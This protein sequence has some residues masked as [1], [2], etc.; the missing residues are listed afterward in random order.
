MVRSDPDVLAATRRDPG[1]E[2]R[3]ALLGQLAF[4][5]MALFFFWGPSTGASSASVASS[6]AALGFNVL[7]LGALAGASSASVTSSMAEVLPASGLGRFRGRP[8]GLPVAF[9]LGALDEAA[10]GFLRC[11]GFSDCSRLACGAAI[12]SSGPGPCDEGTGSK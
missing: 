9:F 3:G 10:L 11:A 5:V 2:F 6:I 12:A 1:A 7:F 4:V 8:G